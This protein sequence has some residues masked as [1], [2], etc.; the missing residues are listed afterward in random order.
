MKNDNTVAH[1]FATQILEQIAQEHHVPVAQV[2][3]EIES[4]ISSAK[5][6]ENPTAKRIWESIPSEGHTPTPEEFILW[7]ASQ[8]RDMYN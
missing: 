6:N 2:R 1:Q 7:A 4:A 3:Q 5:G 8:I